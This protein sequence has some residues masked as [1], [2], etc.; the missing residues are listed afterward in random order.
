MLAHERNHA[1]FVDAKL[2]LN[3]LK[4]RAVFPRHLYDAVNS[5]SV[6]RNN[7]FFHSHIISDEAQFARAK[8]I[9]VRNYNGRRKL[10]QRY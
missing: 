10:S 6:E 4:R 1:R 2:N 9:T 8:T 7:F 3:R 5:S